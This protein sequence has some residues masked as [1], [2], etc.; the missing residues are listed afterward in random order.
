MNFSSKL[1]LNN[2]VEIPVLGLG[3]YQIGDETATYNAVRYAIDVGYRHIDTAAAYHN[4]TGIGKAIGLAALPGSFFPWLLL[5]VAA[6]MILVTI[7]KK[8]FVKRYG[9]LL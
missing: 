7:S 2:G 4:E 8:F 6:Y 3:T 1:K 9:S 5:T